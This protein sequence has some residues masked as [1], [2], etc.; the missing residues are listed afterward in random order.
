MDKRPLIINGEP[1]TALLYLRT[2]DGQDWICG[3]MLSDM[4]PVDHESGAEP[5]AIRADEDVRL[6]GIEIVVK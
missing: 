6:V 3:A 1:Q 5:R 2:S 4:R